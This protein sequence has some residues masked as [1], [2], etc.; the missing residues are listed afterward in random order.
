M[1]I[2]RERFAKNIREL[3]LKKG[4]SQEDLAFACGL[5][6]TYVSD[7]ERAKRNVSID[8]IEKI[9]GAL[10]VTPEELMK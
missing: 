6:R 1:K 4:I 7:I 9:A 8:N 2:L 5:H 10:N 3:R